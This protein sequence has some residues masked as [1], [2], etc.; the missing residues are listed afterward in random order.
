MRSL[1][2]SLTTDFSLVPLRSS[3]I[4][5]H[6]D[7]ALFEIGVVVD[8]ATELAQRWAPI[9]ETLSSLDNVH[10]RLYLNPSRYLD[11]LPIKRFYQYTFKPSLEFDAD[12]GIEKQPQ[13]VFEGIPE[14]VLLTFAMDLQRSWLAFPKSCI[15]DLDNIRLADLSASSRTTGVKAV[16]ELESIIVE[17]H[18]RDMPAGDPPRG[19]QLEL[20]SGTSGEPATTVGTIVMSNLGYFQLKANPGLWRLAIREGRSADVF[21][22]ESIGAQGW[23]SGE[24]ARTGHSLEVTTLEGL[25]IYPR[26]RRRKGQETTELLEMEGAAA[27]GEKPVGVVDRLKSMCVALDCGLRSLLMLDLRRFPF[28]VTKLETNALATTAKRADINVFT[29]ASGLLYEVSSCHQLLVFIA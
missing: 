10:L 24:V 11:E 13:V 26:F 3:I 17:G 27:K 12:T 23:K 25:T 2:S 15:H 20:L 1:P 6:A 4:G 5:E 18:A 14:D 22:V 9:I 19:L 28:F 8:P 29:V 16:F 21:D 7:S